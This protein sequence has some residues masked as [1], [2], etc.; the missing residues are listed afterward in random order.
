MKFTVVPPDKE[1]GTG[2]RRVVIVAE[3][4]RSQANPNRLAGPF[5]LSGGST[6]VEFNAPDKPGKYVVRVDVGLGTDYSSVEEFEV[7]AP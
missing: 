2:A 6:E 7:K 1:T 3:A 4:D 5:P